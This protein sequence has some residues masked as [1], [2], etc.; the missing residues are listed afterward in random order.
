MK[1]ASPR[2]AEALRF[3]QREL[4]ISA[5]LGYIAIEARPFETKMTKSP[6]MLVAQAL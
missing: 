3:V 6:K 1:L 2:H 5:A 4:Q